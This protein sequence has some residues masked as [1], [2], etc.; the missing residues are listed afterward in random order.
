[1]YYF[2][3]GSNMNHKQMKERCPGGT[4]IGSAHL[5]N[6]DLVF[7]GYSKTWDGPVANIIQMSGA[8]VF[9]GLF[10]IDVPSR[11]ALDKAEGYPKNYNRE[12]KLVE[13]GV[14]NKYQA[15][16]YFR[17]PLKPGDPPP[18]CMKAVLDGA[19]DCG[20]SEVY[21]AKYFANFN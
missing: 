8:E 11:N 3:Y 16:V 10:R 20:L 19:R 12:E 6:F 21:I 5:N 18:A 14:G 2:A 17:S 13:D 15:L 4:F 9:G 1:M 7:D